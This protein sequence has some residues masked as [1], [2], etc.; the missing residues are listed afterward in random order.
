MLIE[1]R[2]IIVTEPQKLSE[3]RLS[4]L[5][6]IDRID[7]SSLK[8]VLHSRDR[9]SRGSWTRRFPA[10]EIA[11]LKPAEI[12]RWLGDR[13]GLDP[14]VGRYMVDHLG[15]DL[16]TLR[17]EV[18]KLATYANNRPIRIRDV[19]VL[20]FR[21]ERFGTFEL[22]DALAAR[23]YAR[24][25]QVAGAMLDEGT[26]PILVLSRITRVW[27]QLMVGKSLEGRAG[28]R[29]IAAAASVPEW[30]AA[31]FASSASTYAWPRLLNGF[32]ELLDADRVLKTSTPDPHG[33]FAL[34]LWKLAG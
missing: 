2:A 24:S 31:S 16:C 4:D 33:Y 12:V 1:R 10:I 32:Q 14:K 11:A 17:S 29:D 20:V 21:A 5:T 19:D 13:Y 7:D 25:V 9:R 23:N 6:A 22:D 3:N 34:L 28:A 8:L 27:R 26:E 30:K 15:T 18:E